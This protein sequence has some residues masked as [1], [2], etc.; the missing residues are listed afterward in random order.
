MLFKIR[1]VAIQTDIGEDWEEGRTLSNQTAMNF[2]TKL[3]S[4]NTNIVMFFEP[5]MTVNQC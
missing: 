4:D 3:Q 2:D 1:T 5:E